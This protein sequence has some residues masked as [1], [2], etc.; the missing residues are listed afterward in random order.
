M[1][2]L[3]ARDGVA[4]NIRE[5]GEGP[6]LLVVPGWGGSTLWFHKQFTDAFTDRYRVVCYDPRGQGDSEKTARG[7]R[8]ARLAAD[9]AEVID[10]CDRS[11]VHLLG[12]S[13]GGSTAMQYIELYGETRLAS[14]TLC[15]TGPKLMTSDDW[16]YGF[17]DLTGASAWVDLVRKDL[18]TAA[19]G[20][21][22]HFFASELPQE[23]F[24]RL[25]NDLIRGHSEGMAR[26]SWDFMIQDF[27][28]VLP[29]VTVPTLVLTGEQDVSAPAGNAAYLHAHIP[30]ARLRTIPNAAHC[31]F[32]E[33]PEQF[34]A[35][36]LDF[37]QTIR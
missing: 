28:D 7:Q 25:F 4:L 12:W 1:A 16:E 22:P 15:D 2:M 17:L 20:V 32:L 19:K 34:N 36:V 14:L 37:L 29:L 18:E 11:Q 31:P 6:T 26:A 13:G 21:L 23:E 10:Y 30:E 8:V 27:R 3:K 9:L 24:D 33:R 35:A 5:M